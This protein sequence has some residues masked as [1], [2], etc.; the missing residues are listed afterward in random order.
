MGHGTTWITLVPGYDTLNHM[1]EG[2]RGFLFDS[3][4]VVQHSVAAL[5]VFLTDLPLSDIVA[6]DRV[7]K[8]LPIDEEAV[9]RLR[10][11][12]LIEGRKPNLHVS[13]AIANV[14][15]KRAEYIRTR[16]Q[17]DE[18][19]RKLILDYLSNVQTASRAEIDDLL[20]KNLSD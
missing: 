18:H 19:Y 11:Q 12:K 8:G 5:L 7:Q 3:P 20:M 17:D 15:G 6:L 2:Q 13:S 14:T 4:V 9:K 1:L 10:R 16:S